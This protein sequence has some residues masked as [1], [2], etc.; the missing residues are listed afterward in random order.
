MAEGYYPIGLIVPSRYQL[1]KMITPLL[2]RVI[3]GGK[4]I[5]L[6]IWMGRRRLL[7]VRYFHPDDLAGEIK[8][9]PTDA[10][11]GR[12]AL[13]NNPIIDTEIKIT[14]NGRRVE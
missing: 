6:L 14:A 9:V 4:E 13:G 8:Q 1:H 5:H 12:G 7:D 11:T 2:I 10:A 3:E